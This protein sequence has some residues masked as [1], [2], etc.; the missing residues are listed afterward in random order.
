MRRRDWGGIVGLVLLLLVMA[1]ATLGPLLAPYGAQDLVG[2]PLQ[3]P[4]QKFLLGTDVLGRDLLT[5]L[6]LG[7]RT[8][9]IVA[10]AA[11]SLTMMIAVFV[12]VLGGW[13]G[14]VVDAFVRRAIDITLIVPRLPMLIIFGIYAGRSLLSVVVVI[15]SVS[16]AGPARVLRARTLGLRNR[17]DLRA[18]KGFGAHGGYLF[19]HHVLP[20]VAP[21]MLASF[22]NITSRAV[23]LEAGLA[24][25]GIG[26]ITRMSWG[27]TMRDAV[28]FESLFEM[29]VWK[30]WL[31]PPVVAVS[32]LMIALTL[33]GSILDAR[34]NPRV[35][36]RT[37]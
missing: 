19:A 16:W 23:V 22:V 35:M 15:T 37:S 18:A 29:T 25:L 8:S 30:W 5:H 14:G 21:I 20:E 10:I 34:A 12:G 32:T 7:T 2:E 33:V 28:S 36:V 1:V 26:D 31:V 24:F 6:L 3:S 13:F 11:A 17:A 4:S 27:A 9:M